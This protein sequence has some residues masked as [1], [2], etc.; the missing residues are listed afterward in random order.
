MEERNKK[1]LYSLIENMRKNVGDLIERTEYF[2]SAAKE[3]REKEEYELL[4]DILTDLWNCME[5]TL[6]RVKQI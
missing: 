6:G 1:E 3:I 5:E 4:D 2:H